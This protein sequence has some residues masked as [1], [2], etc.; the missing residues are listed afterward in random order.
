MTSEGQRRQAATCGSH[1]VL[2]AQS[3][4]GGGRSGV[5]GAMG[6]PRGPQRQWLGTCQT[7]TR[8]PAPLGQKRRR[9]LS[10][11]HR[12]QRMAREV[13]MKP[14]GGL[15]TPGDQPGGT[16]P[17]GG[18][19]QAESRPRKPSPGAPG[20]IFGGVAWHRGGTS[21]VKLRICRWPQCRLTQGPSQREAG[22][23]ARGQ[24]RPVRWP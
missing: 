19:C 15:L 3:A 2:G 9:V 12:E 21:G 4:G 6:S 16:S 10:R 20:G 24:R 5:W 7:H 13:Q 14:E 1:Q 8:S 18:G 23:A 11:S 17:L 22:S